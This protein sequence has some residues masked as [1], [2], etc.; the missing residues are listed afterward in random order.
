MT[1]VERAIIVNMLTLHYTTRGL[2]ESSNEPTRP[3]KKD[4]KRFRY[5][6]D[7]YRTRQFLPDIVSQFKQRQYR[8]FKERQYI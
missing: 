4:S 7:G 5:E 2:I 1:E 6:K 8:L 3:I